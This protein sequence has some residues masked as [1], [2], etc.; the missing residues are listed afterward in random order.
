MSKK[1]F[2]I[3][4]GTDI[5]KTYVA[6][7][8]VKT[9]HDAGVRAAYYK[10]AMSGNERLP[11]GQLL[12]GDAAFVQRFSG[13]PQPLTD[14]CP[15]VYEPAVSPH[16]AARMS[17][18]PFRLQTVLDELHILCE[19]YDCVT[20]EGAGG[21]LCPLTDDEAPL[22]LADLIKTAGMS[23]LLVADAGLGTIN[24]VGLTAAY[25][26]ANDI[27]LQGIVL[28]RF[29]AGDIM[30][31]DNRRMCEVVSGA[32]VIATVAYGDTAFERSAEELLSLYT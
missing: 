15:F 11:D 21:I 12:P 17:N 30:H 29:L 23:C 28:N 13:I 31:E 14:M 19:R 1:L 16:L 7:L 32:P 10:A 2:I 20:M 8:I 26:R 25:L 3:G 5:G 24:D 22:Y 9:L 27:P 6:A 18:R 4:T